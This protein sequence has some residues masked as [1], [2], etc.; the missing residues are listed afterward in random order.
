L[1]LTKLTSVDKSVAKKLLQTININDI[2]DLSQTYE[3][4][5]VALMEASTI[6]FPI[7]KVLTTKGYYVVGD[8]GSA[9]YSVFAADD[10]YS[11]QLSN[12]LF[13]RLTSR[14]IFNPYIFGANQTQAND[15]AAVQ[16]LFNY[17][18]DKSIECR[19]GN[20]HYVDNLTVKSGTNIK[21][22]VDSTKTYVAIETYSVLQQV[23]GATQT[24][25]QIVGTYTDRI[26]GVQL[27]NITIWPM[28]N[29]ATNGLF[30]SNIVLS[31]FDNIRITNH[32]VGIIIEQ[33]FDNYFGRLISTNNNTNMKIIAGV[34]DNS[35]NQIFSDVHL[36]THA[37]SGLEIEGVGTG[38]NSN[39]KLTFLR[40]KNESLGVGPNGTASYIFNGCVHVH[41]VHGDCAIPDGS[42]DMPATYKGVVFGN[43]GQPVGSVVFDSFEIRNQHSSISI[44][45]M[46]DIANTNSFKCNLKVA[47]PATGVSANLITVDNATCSNIEFKLMEYNN[48]AG[49]NLTNMTGAVG[50]IWHSHKDLH[51]DLSIIGDN[52]NIRALKIINEDVGRIFTMGQ[53]ASDGAIQLCINNGTNVLAVT[54]G[55]TVQNKVADFQCLG[56]AKGLIVKSPDG[57]LTRRIRIDNSGNIVSEVI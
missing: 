40:L 11:K 55:N 6:V 1:A 5:T 31:S 36:E 18:A 43:N 14:N 4:N 3:F 26:Y 16:L 56:V 28:T 35:N 53:I 44:A 2:N 38:A 20:H 52:S 39:N 19:L 21:G 15:P 22:G 12:G 30:M 13:A 8:A 49:S 37:I 50:S 54:T 47:M 57:L 9:E 41:I 42:V 25:V 17:S 10:G 48:V 29:K 33:C 27:K 24:A 46:F 7:G 32:D 23:S 45:S 51:G 34:E